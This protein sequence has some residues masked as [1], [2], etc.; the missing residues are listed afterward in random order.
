M[1]L[2]NDLV[3]SCQNQ[4]NGLF[5]RNSLFRLHFEFSDCENVETYTIDE[6]NDFNIDGVSNR[7]IFN[8]MCKRHNSEVLSWWFEGRHDL[9]I[10]VKEF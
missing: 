10:Q 3:N 1:L 2:V 8:L 4:W 5:D 7:Y 9:F 6:F